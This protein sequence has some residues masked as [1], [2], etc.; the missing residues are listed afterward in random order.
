MS[1]EKHIKILCVRIEEELYNQLRKVAFRKYKRF[2]GALSLAVREA[3]EEYIN[4]YGAEEKEIAQT[5]QA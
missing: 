1:E 2:H 5:L 4:K 3:F